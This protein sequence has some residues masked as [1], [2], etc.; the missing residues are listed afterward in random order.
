MKKYY[1]TGIGIAILLILSSIILFSADDEDSAHD[2]SPLSLPDS[3][4]DATYRIEGNEF[5]L[6]NGSYEK[7]GEKVQSITEP[8]YG[9]INDDGTEDAVFTLEY[10]QGDTT[11]Y[12]LVA[13]LNDKDGFLGLD[14]LKLNRNDIPLSLNVEDLAITVSYRPVQLEQSHIEHEYYTLTNGLVLINKTPEMEDTIYKGLYV[15]GHESRT[16]TPC[17]SDE[18]YWISAKSGSNAALKAI[19]EEKT[20][21]MEPYTPIYIVLSGH[22]TDA[23]LDGF[24]AE[25]GS[26]IAINTILSIPENGTCSQEQ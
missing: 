25:Y 8:V 13:S 24:G 9:D 19:Y 23:P 1:L 6:L 2:L 22:I 5:T 18:I 3:P 26:A 7:D 11:T 10:S 4:L 20:K 14:G 21:E 16:F 15:Y 17:D 12:Y